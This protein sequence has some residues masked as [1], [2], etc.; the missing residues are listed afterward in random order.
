MLLTYFPLFSIEFHIYNGAI[1][2]KQ[3][4]HLAVR[5]F[6]LYNTFLHELGHIQIILP[7]AKTNRRK[8]AGSGFLELSG[9]KVE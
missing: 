6:L 7:K 1:R 4:P 2:A 3:W 9:G 5:R 8:F